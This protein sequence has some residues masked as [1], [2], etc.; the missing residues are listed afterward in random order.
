M[1]GY[2]AKALA[3]EELQKKAKLSKYDQNLLLLSKKLPS[4]VIIKYMRFFSE[5]EILA[6]SSDE[7]L[8]NKLRLEI[9]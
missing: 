8:L 5:L 7:L 9:L 2:L 6:K 1:Q 4:S 3:H